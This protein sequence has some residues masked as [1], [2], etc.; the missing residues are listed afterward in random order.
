MTQSF[1]LT[2]R[3]IEANRLLGSGA[4]HILLRGGSRSGKT[5]LLVRACFIRA[6]RAAES[7]H[8]IFRFKRNHID[9]SVWQDT[10]PKVKRLCFPG[11]GIKTN[12]TD[13]SVTFANGSQILLGGLDD[14]DR[15]EKILGQEYAT[16]YFN[17]VSQIPY[18]SVEMT[19]TRLAQKTDLPLRA[20]YDCNPPPK[21]H[22]TYQVWKRGLKPG[23]TDPLPDAHLYAEMRIN[24]DDNR[25]N[26]PEEYFGVL[27][28]MGA[29]KRM[30]FEKGEWGAD[31]PGAL[32]IQ[33]ML[34]RDRIG[35]E[36]YPDL[37]RIVVAV[38][39]PVTSGE[40]ADEC[41]IV[42][43]GIDSA[44]EGYVL[45]DRSTKGQTPEQWAR[46]A[47]KAYHEFSADRLVAEVNNGGELVEHV[48]RKVD[49]RISYRAVRASRGKVIRAE[50]VSA[51]YE[52]GKVHHCG[53]F[54]ELE[55]QM[56]SFTSDFD[57]K[58]MGYSPDRVDALVWALTDL[59]VAPREMTATSFRL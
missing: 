11:L 49:N 27:S 56:C 48:M 20:Y 46:A 45:A 47:V 29:A 25:D 43:A 2:E 10:L 3:Q 18:P 26:L 41:G 17:E 28:A 50:P 55:D 38:D 34:D 58:A 42:V 54:P 12:E 22:W 33:D 16:L 6:L 53:G 52:Q 1:R 51:L 30:R 14:K 40:N 37:R 32:W 59:M 7:R 35:A 36:D 9:T 8:A 24:P 4:R 13:M 21:S 15:V 44:G 39:P 5:F 57:S 23:T 19:L 31:T